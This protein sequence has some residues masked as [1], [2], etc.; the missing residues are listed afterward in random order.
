MDVHVLEGEGVLGADQGWQRTDQERGV[1]KGAAFPGLKLRK[2]N[3]HR[4]E[5]FGHG[6]VGCEERRPES[7][8]VVRTR[9]QV[10]L[11]PAVGPLK[12]HLPVT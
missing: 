3:R 12:D 4:A 9:L 7:R 10:E 11:K 1:L 6:F 5:E 8:N 2:G